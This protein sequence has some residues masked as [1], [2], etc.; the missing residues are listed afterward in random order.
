MVL[1]DHVSAIDELAMATERLRVRHPDEPKPNPPVLHIIEPHEVKYLTGKTSFFSE[2][3]KFGDC[4]S[5]VCVCVVRERDLCIS[6]IM[7]LCFNFRMLGWNKQKNM[8][9]LNVLYGPFWVYNSYMD[10]FCQPSGCM[11]GMFPEDYCLSSSRWIAEG[12]VWYCPILQPGGKW[13]WPDFWPAL[14]LSTRTLKK[15]AVKKEKK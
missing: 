11:S 6:S 7:H 1:R 8:P 13:S 4:T 2:R 5:S 14:L 3:I 12:P 9:L 10:I 15:T